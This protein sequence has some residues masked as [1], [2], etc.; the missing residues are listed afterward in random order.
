[1]T[2]KRNYQ[3]ERITNLTFAFL[4]AANQGRGYINA[5]YV[6]KQVPGYRKDEAGNIRKT[7]TAQTMFSRDCANLIAAGVPLESVRVH[8]QV[9][10]RLQTEE[11]ELPS[12]SFSPEE[13]TVLALA[14]KMGDGKQLASFSR[15]G[16]TKIAASGVQSELKATNNYTPINDWSTL[17]A[18]DFDLISTACT[19]KKRISF[20]YQPNT[21]SDYT[22]RWMDPWG[23]VT[24]RDRLYLVGYDLD[25]QAPRCFRITRVFDLSLIDPA[26]VDLE[27]Y[28][29]FQL[30]APN[31]SLIELVEAQLRAGL[32]LIDAVVLVEPGKAE[33]IRSHG[34]HLGDDR[35]RL[36]DVDAD[37]LAR[38]AAALA[39]KVLVESPPELIEKVKDLLKEARDG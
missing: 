35:Y 17:T 36:I 39:P 9:A 10:W 21:A 2:P 6:I 14:G 24:V 27:P 3:L 26:H 7:E 19:E 16:W 33:V 28:G 23:I 15:S 25:R 1:M 31:T 29:Q 37:W 8:G 5:D 30:P 4:Q 13:G 11:Y 22:E 34:E 32:H 12:V 18:K 20:F 38:Q